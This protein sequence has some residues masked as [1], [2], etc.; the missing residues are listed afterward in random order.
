MIGSDQP[1][2]LVAGQ[3]LHHQGQVGRLV[4]DIEHQGLGQGRA[5]GSPRM[6]PRLGR[7]DQGGARQVD[8]ERGALPGRAADADAA[9]HQFDRRAAQRQTDA[10]ASSEPSSATRRV[11]VVE[12]VAN[13]LRALVDRAHA[14]TLTSDDPNERLNVEPN[15]ARTRLLLDWMLPRTHLPKI[16]E[17]DLNVLRPGKLIEQLC[18][19][20]LQQGVKLVLVFRG[21][22]GAIMGRAAASP[23]VYVPPAVVKTIDR[24]VPATPFRWH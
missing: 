9:A 12:P 24:S 22:S 17:G 6:V 18:D 15:L 8:P 10:R 23:V 7:I 5:V 20:A 19:A 16:S 3:D 2:T 21:Q 11:R 13:T 4:L 14:S 1:H